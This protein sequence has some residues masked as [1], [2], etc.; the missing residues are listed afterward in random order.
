MLKFTDSTAVDTSGPLRRLELA[1]GLYVAGEGRFTPCRD[2]AEVRAIL[3][4]ADRF[5]WKMG[6]LEFEVPEGEEKK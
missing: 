3:E 1:G 2:E 5:T 4:A 6:D